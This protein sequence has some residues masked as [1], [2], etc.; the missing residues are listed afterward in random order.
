MKAQA[1]EGYIRMF[2]PAKNNWITW[3]TYQRKFL[4]ECRNQFID[5]FFEY[6]QKR[7]MYSEENLKK[8]ENFILNSQNVKSSNNDQNS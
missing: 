6:D 8:I 4:M 3:S 5:F 2:L 1:N 7:S